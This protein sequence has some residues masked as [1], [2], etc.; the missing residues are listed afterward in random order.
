MS[1][2]AGHEA[3]GTY[4][5]RPADVA[6]IDMEFLDVGDMHQ[7]EQVIDR[8][9][10]D[11]VVHTAFDQADWTTTATGTAHVALAAARSGAR[12]VAISSDAV[13]G[14]RSDPY[15]ESASPSPV[16][17]Y[18]AA[19]AAAETAVTAVVPSAAVVRTSLIVGDDGATGHERHVHDAIA[20]PGSRVFFTDDV[21][22]PV[23]VADLAS[24]VLE[25]ADSPRAGIHHVAGADALS[26]HDLAMLI[27]RRDGLESSAL[28]G[29][30]RH[31]SGLSAGATVRLDCARTQAGLNT[32]L[33]GAREFLS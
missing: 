3:V 4:R 16:T 17:A 10:P 13:F 1:Q 32:R 33:R 24:A 19:K 6:G 20:D 28:R 9:R 8:T 7:V 21:R 11:V 2:A 29:G 14:G 30:L 27:A 22:C 23:H 5:R 25:I 12:L 31:E 18:G 26:R 15:P